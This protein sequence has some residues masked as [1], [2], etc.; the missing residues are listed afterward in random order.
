MPAIMVAWETVAASLRVLSPR[1]SSSGA[2][3][4]VS[5]QDA[6][7]TVSGK[8]KAQEFS[9]QG[10]GESVRDRKTSFPAGPIGGN[11]PGLSGRNFDPAVSAFFAEEYGERCCCRWERLP[12]VQGCRQAFGQ[13]LVRIETEN[14]SRNW[15]EIWLRRSP[16]AG[17]DNPGTV[18][19]SKS[20]G[21]VARSVVDDEDAVARIEGFE[22]TAQPQG[23]VLGV[24]QCGD[25][26]HE[27]VKCT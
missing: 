2:P 13:G 19:A 20:D 12:L 7:R 4:P 18:L 10:Q 27:R 3:G 24:K 1:Y 15:G 22:C 9:L 8:G 16:A 23:V 6:G 5:I 21:G 14:P 17:L 25:R 11:Q 26:G